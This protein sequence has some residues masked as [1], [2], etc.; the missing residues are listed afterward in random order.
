MTD[1]TDLARVE[2]AEDDN[3]RQDVLKFLIVGDD[4]SAHQDLFFLI[5]Q[6]VDLAVRSLSKGIN[7]PFT[8]MS[9]ADWLGALLGKLGRKTYPTG[10]V[11]GADGQTGVIYKSES[12]RQYVEAVW[13]RLRPYLETDPNAALYMLDRGLATVE[14]LPPARRPAVAAAMGRLLEGCSRCFQ[15]SG[16]LA[17]LEERRRGLE[18]LSQVVA[19]L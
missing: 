11:G 9:A 16:D 7:D 15:H 1:A 10:W 17:A 4:R 19:P 13:D 2:C 14:E 5:E 8:A 18:S 3:Q 12:F 6:Q